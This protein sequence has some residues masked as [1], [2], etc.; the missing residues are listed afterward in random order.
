MAEYEVEAFGGCHPNVADCG[1]F[2]LMA[3]GRVES[4][5]RRAGKLQVSFS[6][7]MACATRLQTK[8][9]TEN[10]HSMIISC[11]RWMF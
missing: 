5:L 6:N 1:A 11:T 2:L 3:G 8:K 7:H 10:S 9:G 4:R